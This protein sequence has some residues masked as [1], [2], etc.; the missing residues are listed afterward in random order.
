MYLVQKYGGRYLKNTEDL[1]RITDN[2][3]KNKDKLGDLVI[4]TAAMHDIAREIIG[5]AEQFQK[6]I[7]KA[8]LDAL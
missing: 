3:A 2:I 7:G 8:E 1:A 5:R 6:G 4:V